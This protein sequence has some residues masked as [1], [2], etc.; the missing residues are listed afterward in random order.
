MKKIS[1]ISAIATL[2]LPGFAYASFTDLT[3]KVS[4]WTR[5]LIPLIISLGLVYFLWG[6]FLYIK[7]GSDEASKSSSKQIMYNGVIA[8][9]VMISVWGLVSLLQTSL[10]IGGEG[11]IEIYK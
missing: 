1:K 8:L 4:G 2:L 11:A 3:G 7:A 5:D 10:G 6:V 9:F